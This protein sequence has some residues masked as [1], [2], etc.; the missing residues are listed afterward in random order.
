MRL[1]SWNCCAGPLEPKRRALDALQADIAVVPESPKG[2]DN[3]PTYVWCGDNPKKGMAVIAAREW[4]L[5][6]VDGWQ[7]LPKHFV[8]IMVEGPVSFLLIAV[9]S[10]KAG[11]DTYVRGISRAIDLMRSEILKQPTV[12]IG[13]FNS[14]TIF[15]SEHPSDFNHT[16]MVR[17]MD[18]LGLKSAY[19]HVRSE[20]HGRETAHTYYHYRKAD[21]GFHIDFCF[22]PSSWTLSLQ[23]DVGTFDEWKS[24]SDHVPLIVNVSGT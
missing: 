2:G 22:V 17:R 14:N 9:W 15:D 24:L 13:D 5:A 20:E 12:I 23:V 16:A 10:K 3:S 4:R 1:V 6:C 18:E 7:H 11:A 8:P 19:H 21:R